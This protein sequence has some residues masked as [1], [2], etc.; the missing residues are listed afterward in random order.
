MPLE[1]SQLK[2]ETTETILLAILK[3]GLERFLFLKLR[4]TQ[5][6]GKAKSRKNTGRRRKWQPHP[7][8]DGRKVSSQMTVNAQRGN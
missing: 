3:K 8:Q 6:S 5:N 2:K 1:F 4:C 7:T